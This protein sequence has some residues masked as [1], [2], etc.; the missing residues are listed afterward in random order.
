MLV[1]WWSLEDYGYSIW[2]LAHT[3]SMAIGIRLQLGW[4]EYSLSVRLACSYPD[5]TTPAP[6][7]ASHPTGVLP[8]MSRHSSLQKLIFNSLCLTI[9]AITIAPLG[10]TGEEPLTQV[11]V[12]EAG[13]GGYAMYRIP[14]VVVTPKGTILAYCEARRTGKSDWDEINILMRRSIDGGKTFLEPQHVAHQ[15]DKVPKNPLAIKQKLGLQPEATVNNPV[16][17]VDRKSG[18]ITMLYCVEYSRCFAMHSDDEGA[19]F[20]KP[21]DITAALEKLRQEYPWF[22]VAI[23]PGHAIQLKNGRLVAA[24]W[25][26][27]GEGGHAHRPSVTTTLVSDDGGETWSAGE[28]AARPTDTIVNPNETT[29]AELS[30][31]TVMLNIRSESKPNR[32]LITLSKN[33]SS[34]WSEPKFDEALVEPICMASLLAVPTREQQLLIYAGPDNLTSA[35]TKEPKPGTGRDRKNLTV[36][37]S[38]DDGQTWTAKRVL[39]PGPSAYSDLA[40][41]PDGRVHCFFERCKAVGTG[42]PYARLSLVS[43]KPDWITQPATATSK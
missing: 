24:V 40:V 26:S 17:V 38:R 1:G 12:F 28:I 27:T 6:R 20:S 41:G 37:L 25:L 11:D 22:V 19:T 31:G 29:L 35:K 7:S 13:V 43:F 30:D 2:S 9:L 23:G 18:R 15:G 36:Q 10:A 16:A 14:G 39:E 32:R 3:L 34:G 21:R 33:G 42:S 5:C 4:P 8:A